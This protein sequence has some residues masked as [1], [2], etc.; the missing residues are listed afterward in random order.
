MRDLIPY[1][2]F[3]V[4]AGLILGFNVG[5]NM[6]RDMTV[7]DCLTKQEMRLDNLDFTCELKKGKPNDQP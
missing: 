2:A 7:R 3:S 6:L 4:F 5:G 1:I